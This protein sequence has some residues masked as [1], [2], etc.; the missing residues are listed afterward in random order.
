MKI[1]LLTLFL[2]PFIKTQAQQLFYTTYE[3]S[4][5]YLNVVEL[6]N[7]QHNLKLLSFPNDSINSIEIKNQRIYLT[8]V[9]SLHIVDFYS[10]DDLI[11]DTKKSF[12]VKDIN[13][14]YA[15][16]S[17]VYGLTHWTQ[18]TYTDYNGFVF[19][20]L[21]SLDDSENLFSLNDSYIAG[22][23]KMYDFV[24]LTDTSFVSLVFKHSGQKDEDNHSVNKY[25]Y[26]N[27]AT[28]SFGFNKTKTYLWYSGSSL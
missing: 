20:A 28:P 15:S 1:K 5:S 6:Q 18:S 24:F 21:D 7:K 9:D 23:D 14:I 16:E 19:G 10:V 25:V 8:G 4:V 2:I 11:I 22:M 26:H 13:K 17:Y 12:Y 3:D 27:N